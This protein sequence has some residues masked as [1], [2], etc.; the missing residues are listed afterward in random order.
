MS[1][2]VTAPLMIIEGV[3]AGFPLIKSK[4]LDHGDPTA[5]TKAR[6]LNDWCGGSPRKRLELKQNVRRI[7]YRIKKKP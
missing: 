1:T 5:T 3:T 4:R 2:P 6:R 7:K